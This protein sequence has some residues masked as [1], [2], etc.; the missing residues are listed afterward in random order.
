MSKKNKH[1][2]TEEIQ[3]E[4]EAMNRRNLR[5]FGYQTIREFTDKFSLGLYE[6]MCNNWPSDVDELHHPED[7]ASNV[8]TYAEAVFTTIQTFGAGNTNGK[9]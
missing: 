7:L 8:L 6:Y 2:S 4:H 1:I 3:A 5:E 9:E